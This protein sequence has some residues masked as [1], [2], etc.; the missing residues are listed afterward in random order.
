MTLLDYFRGLG[1][2]GVVPILGYAGLRITGLTTEQCLRDPKLHAEVA[3]TGLLHFQPDAVLPLLDLTVEAESYGVRPTFQG[4]EAPMITDQMPLESINDLDEFGTSTNRMSTMV[5]TARLISS[6]VKDT[7]K[8]FFVT[9]PFTLAGQIV[10]IRALLTTVSLS[11]PAVASLVENCTETVVDYAKQLA[12][13]GIDF[14]VI[15]DP[16]ASL[17]SLKQFEETAKV[18]L[19]RVAKAFEKDAV[20]HICGRSGHLLRQMAETG[21]T[22]ISIDQNVRLS[23]AVNSV[24]SSVLVFGNYSPANLSFQKPERIRENVEAMLAE[25]GEADNVV[26]STGCDVPSSTPAEN[27]RAFV[28][29]TKSHVRQGR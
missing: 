25:L 29:A 23:E 13:T 26:A 6:Q 11:E 10:G 2:V 8:G 20:L 1:R 19:T 16:T 28:Q 5:E 24:Q 9:G 12:E 21:V 17:I 4:M 3:R 27:I 22:G 18:P 7:L 14:L 15:A